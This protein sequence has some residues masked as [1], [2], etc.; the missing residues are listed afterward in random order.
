MVFLCIMFA[1]LAYFEYI[2][3]GGL[4]HIVRNLT[5]PDYLS[6]SLAKYKS[7]KQWGQKGAKQ[8]GT[9]HS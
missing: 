8:P 5:M 6:T 3:V 1:L 7:L 9:H 4:F 2:C